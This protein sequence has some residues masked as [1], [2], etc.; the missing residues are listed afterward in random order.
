MDFG[1]FLQS[2]FGSWM[3]WVGG[4]LRL[5]PFFESLVEPSLRKKLPKVDAWFIAKGSVL[6]KNLTLIA[7]VCLFIGCYRAWVFEHR[8]AQMAMY[9]K[10][11]KS[12]AWSKYNEC[13]KEKAIKSALADTYATQIAG[14]RVQLDREQDTFNRCILTLGQSTMPRPT[15]VKVRLASIPIGKDQAGNEL[16]EWII[17]ATVSKAVSPFNGRLR[18][19]EAVS[20][21]GASVSF[22]NDDPM[23]TMSVGPSRVSDREFTLQYVTPPIWLPDSPLVFVAVQQQRPKGCVVLPT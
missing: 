23:T 12:A 20:V 5:I 18:C 16:K 9:G 22:S 19:E 10:D 4:I 15:N 14:Q 1:L 13:D 6:K 3:V 17:V 2:L 21:V 11:G 8:N 7:M